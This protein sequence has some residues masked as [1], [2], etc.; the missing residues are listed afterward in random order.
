M[1]HAC[2][3]CRDT[4]YLLRTQDDGTVL[5]APCGCAPPDRAERR[6]AA[7]GIPRRYE[8]CTLE[9]FEGIDPSQAEARNKVAQWIEDWP[10]ARY[11]LLLLGRPGTGKTHLAVAAARALIRDRGARVL[12]YEQRQLLKDLQGTFDAAAP[13]RESEVF[14]PVLEAELLVLD[15]LGAGRTTPWAR[16]VLHDVIAQ[17]YNDEKPMLITSN[18]P[19]GDEPETAQAGR[20]R[21]IDAPLTLRDRL[22]EALISRLYEM[23]RIVRIRGKKEM[24]YRREIRNAEYPR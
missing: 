15:D 3:T 5:A 14:G 9:S 23:C 12:F 21:G 10:Q 18:L 20:A 1:S 17:R 7:A 19:I 6:L 24:D 2:V 4:G 8:H 22:G 16:D 11:G 13:Q